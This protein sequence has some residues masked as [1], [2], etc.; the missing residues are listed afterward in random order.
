MNYCSSLV[1]NYAVIF[2]YPCCWPNFLMARKPSDAMEGYRAPVQSSPMLYGRPSGHITYVAG[3]QYYS[4]MS[5]GAVNETWSTDYIRDKVFRRFVHRCWDDRIIFSC[6]IHD[7]FDRFFCIKMQPRKTPLS[8]MKIFIR[9]IKNRQQFY[10]CLLLSF[11]WWI[12]MS[13]SQQN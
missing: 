11:L 4:T 6:V 9:Q 5:H 8:C 12:R 3:Q 13:N 7:A 2:V 10:F 1:I